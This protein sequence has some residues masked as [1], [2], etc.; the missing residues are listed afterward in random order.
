M[1][2]IQNILDKA[3]REGAAFHTSSLGAP[4]A[5]MPI[6][7]DSHAPVAPADQPLAPLAPAA[8]GSGHAQTSPAIAPGVNA[9]TAGTGAP[10][11][12]APESVTAA[13]AT[14]SYL[15]WP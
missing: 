3:E 5:A 6:A 10:G 13:A 1:S 4:T 12:D 7:A 9:A 11:T 8:F 2:R 14:V 15:R